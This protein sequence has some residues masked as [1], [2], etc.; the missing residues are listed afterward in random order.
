MLTEAA[1]QIVAGTNYKLLIEGTP[2]GG[3]TKDY[4]AIVFAPLG[5]G[6]DEVKSIS[7]VGANLLGAPPSPAPLLG[8]PPSPQPLLTLVG[9]TQGP[10][11]G[12]APAAKPTAPKAPIA[13]VAPKPKPGPVTPA[14]APA[15]PSSAN[16]V[17]FT[18]AGVAAVVVG[19]AM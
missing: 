11:T 1:S 4:E 3:K 2:K 10:A 15:T 12:P 6:A 16:G 5:N 17:S 13:P 18:L 7:E 9:G 8:A 19:L 14:P